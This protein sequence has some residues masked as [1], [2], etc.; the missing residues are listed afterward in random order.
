MD[1]WS[2]VKSIEGKINFD[3]PSG[4]P[5][6]YDELSAPDGWK[7]ADTTPSGIHRMLPDDYTPPV[8]LPHNRTLTQAS[9]SAKF[10]F[11]AGLLIFAGCLALA[12]H[13]A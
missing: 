3:Y 1:E 6:R 13:F 9:F 12:V 11:A 7:I 2:K 8:S 5:R 10:W 4:D